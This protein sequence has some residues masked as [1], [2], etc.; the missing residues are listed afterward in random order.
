ML[1]TSQLR[2]VV[3]PGIDGARRS[4]GNPRRARS[5]SA[6][7]PLGL[8]AAL[9]AI[10]ARSAAQQ[11][12]YY[13]VTSPTATFDPISGT[14]WASPPPTLPTPFYFQF[15]QG[16]LR[17]M[18]AVGG[19]GTLQ[20]GD[21]V[22]L[23]LAASL[24]ADIT[25]GYP[26]PAP[27]CC[28]EVGF[29]GWVSR[30]EDWLTPAF[31]SGRR[32]GID[33]EYYTYNVMSDFLALIPSGT[34]R[35]LRQVYSGPPIGSFDYADQRNW[36]VRVGDIIVV[37][38]ILMAGDN[39]G[40]A[41][42]LQLAVTT[43]TP[44]ATLDLLGDADGDG[45]PDLWDTYPNDATRATPRANPAS[46]QILIDTS[47]NPGTWLSNVAAF[48][49]TDP[50]P[51]INQNGKPAGVT[52]PAG[53]VTF[54]VNGV[55]PGGTVD[56]KL[57][58]PAPLPAGS[59]YYK[60]DSS[61]FHLFPGAVVN[62]NTVTLTLTDGGSGD[63]DGVADGGISDPGGIAVPVVPYQ[64]PVANAG[65]N[66]SALTGVPIT[67]AGSA[68]DPAGLPITSWSWTVTQA[69]APGTWGL[70]SANTPS[71]Q[72]TGLAPG[73]YTVSLVVADAQGSSAPDLV[74]VTVADNLPPTA[75]IALQAGYSAAG[76]VPLTV[77][78]DGSGS[79]DPEGMP[80]TYAWDFGNGA[81]SADPKPC[82][83]YQNP[84]KYT[85][86]LT[87]SDPL[88]ATGSDLL[89]VT[90]DA[91]AN[92][93]PE[94]SPTA[95]PQT[96]EAPLTVQFAANASDPDPGDTLTYAWTFGDPASGDDTSA[97][98]NPTHRYAL[99]GTYVAWL[100]VSDGKA[101]VSRSI[102]I[103]VSPSIQLSVRAAVL[104]WWKKPLLGA[105]TLWADFASPLPAPDDVVLVS[106][107]GI[108]LLAQPFGA[109]R[110]EPGTE[111]YLF[112]EKGLT[113][114]LDFR[115]G[116]LFLHVPRVNLQQLDLSNGVD[117][118]LFLGSRVGVENL[119]MT[120]THHGMVYRRSPPARDDEESEDP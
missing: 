100:T 75:V 14:T 46:P 77:C 6:A 27:Y 61:G 32:L 12:V 86:T 117:V 25:A 92:H 72:F 71:A 113:A 28:S 73:S 70:T 83:T 44:G 120:P 65:G 95:T 118:E 52:F 20:T 30:L 102:T 64:P 45:V 16:Y 22:A 119:A 112:H 98:A 37:E 99:P 110:T 19:G 31:K 105:V 15:G 24:H 63:W 41:G 39:P 58:Y 85:V 69:P 1:R 40:T 66:R 54:R 29:Y 103:A 5:R 68:V 11:P 42:V 108:T 79:L 88:G 2:E 84:G 93:P 55:A 8:L 78:L 115:K 96:G 26:A 57:I 18:Y 94:A 33:G 97:L 104:K 116:R 60:V 107:D 59:Q 53:L 13:H 56:V 4:A 17:R 51:Y 89:V 62:G 91:P 35:D 67:L 9:A 36:S 81:T 82:T 34:A 87:V 7:L 49:D 111:R 3:L 106:F 47:A 21:P 114:K 23:V 101:S 50:Y 76:I 43:P 74:V 48:L 109:F 38:S 10:P 90:A 80:L